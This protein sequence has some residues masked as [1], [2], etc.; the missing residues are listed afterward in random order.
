MAIGKT[1]HVSFE[2]FKRNYLI[3]LGRELRF[4]DPMHNSFFILLSEMPFT[5]DPSIPNDEHRESDGRD[6]RR[7]YSDEAGV[8]VDPRD[9]DQMEMWEA[10]VLEVLTSLAMAA[11]DSSIHPAY[12]PRDGVEWWFWRMIV[13]LGLVAPEDIEPIR[14]DNDWTRIPDLSLAKKVIV[15]WLERRYSRTGKGGIFPVPRT[16]KD[17]R[18]VELWYQM[19]EYLD[20]MDA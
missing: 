7:L 20:Y 8:E 6:L 10:S 9:Y 11:N 15:K 17:Q 16:R 19:A 2:T 3:N 18:K 14:R 5:W 13:N 1:R 12:S 4:S